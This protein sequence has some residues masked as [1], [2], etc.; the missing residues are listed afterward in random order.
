M[1]RNTIAILFGIV[2][3]IY[4]NIISI[5]YSS[6][7]WFIE[8]YN[9]PIKKWQKILDFGSFEFF[10]SILI[11]YCSSIFLST[12]FTFFFVFTAKQAYAVFLTLVLSF[13]L[14]IHNLYY[15]IPLWVRINT[16]FILFFFLWFIKK[17][18]KEY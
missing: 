3:T 4:I 17:Y 6:K 13:F 9:I 8:I 14:E 12:L 15:S 5:E 10:I 1:L 7:E 2:M 18:Y 11:F 16:F